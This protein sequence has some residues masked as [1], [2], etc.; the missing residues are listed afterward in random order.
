MK[1]L[2]STTLDWITHPTHAEDS[3]PKV[4]AAGLLLILIVSF[5]WSFTVRQ[6]E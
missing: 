3:S 2:I 4:W 5:L 6:F 1:G